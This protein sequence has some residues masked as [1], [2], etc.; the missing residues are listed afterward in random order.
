[1][2]PEER[3]EDSEEQEQLEDEGD[4]ELLESPEQYKDRDW[5]TKI[6]RAR[7]AREQTLKLRQERPARLGPRHGSAWT[8]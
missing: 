2:E 3:A 6:A 4:D 8:R 7:E 5:A 1:V